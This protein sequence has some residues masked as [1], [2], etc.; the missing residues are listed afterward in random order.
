MRNFNSLCWK[1]P[2]F[3][4]QQVS[5]VTDIDGVTSHYQAGLKIIN[6]RGLNGLVWFHCPSQLRESNYTYWS[7]GPYLF[8]LSLWNESNCSWAEMNIWTGL[9][10]SGT[11]ICI[12]T[13]RLIPVS[14]NHV[15]MPHSCTTR[16]TCEV[17]W[18]FSRN[19][20]VQRILEVN[21]F[22]KYLL[23]SKRN[24]QAGSLVGRVWK[25]GPDPAFPPSFS[26][27]SCIPHFFHRYPESR[28]FFP[29]NTFKKTTFCKG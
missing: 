16:C 7:K 5:C 12:R 23:R 21:H 6:L 28:F 11:A 14:R 29:K 20:R 19:S 3:S 17:G 13:S 9:I 27:E 22:D 2:L 1:I 15:A 26:R 4:V 24:I 18:K 25:G 10:S 8:H